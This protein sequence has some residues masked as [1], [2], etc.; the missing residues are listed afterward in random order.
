MCRPRFQIHR[1]DLFRDRGSRG[2]VNRPTPGEGC[3][4]AFCN[5]M[6][7]VMKTAEKMP[8][9][10]I[11]VV[12]NRSKDEDLR[13]TRRVIRQLEALGFSALVA[14]DVHA[15]TGAGLPVPEAEVY[16]ASDFLIC[17]GG[18]GTFLQTA[19]KTLGHE[20]PILGINLG[21]LGFLAEV[22]LDQMDEAL[23]RLAAG[24]VSVS[25]RLV[26]QASVIRDG[27]VVHV[28]HAINDAVVTR[29]AVSRIVELHVHVD[30]HFVDTFPSDGLIVATPT[31]STAYTLSAGGPIVLPEVPLMV[32]TPICPHILYSR[33]FIVP[34]HSRL[35]IRVGDRRNANAML[36]CDGRDGFALELNDEVEIVRAPERILFASVVQ[37][38]FYE[39]LRAKIHGRA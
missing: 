9:K 35:T 8:Y 37:V 21:S 23:Q 5:D 20:K 11:G 2:H 30:G 36:S 7:S 15:Q 18:D 32:I 10:R 29:M 31:G 38:N 28:D 6:M 27:R 19:R 14:P 33:S 24:E 4:I 13:Q 16:A 39:V 17:L 25:P 26:L 12:V 3:V 22:E 1:D 34:T